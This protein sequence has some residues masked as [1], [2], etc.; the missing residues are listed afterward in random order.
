VIKLSHTVVDREMCDYD[1]VIVDL[2]KD[3]S[4]VCR[5]TPR[6]AIIRKMKIKKKKP[7]EVAWVYVIVA[8]A[9]RTHEAKVI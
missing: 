9:E 8:M 7:K 5:L 4:A 3:S 1:I 6:H 2:V